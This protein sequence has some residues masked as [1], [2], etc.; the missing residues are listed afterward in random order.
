MEATDWT[1]TSWGSAY[2]AASGSG[3]Q[4]KTLVGGDSGL[5]LGQAGRELG[6]DHRQDVFVFLVDDRGGD[7]LVAQRL[8]LVADNT[9]QV[10]GIECR[11]PAGHVAGVHRRV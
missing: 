4:G 10:V 9:D 6:L 2:R 3:R 1:A 5:E 11:G 8:A 7:H